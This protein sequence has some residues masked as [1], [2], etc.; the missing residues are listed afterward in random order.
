[1]ES[2]YNILWTDHAL[3][4]LALTF[5]YL[6]INFTEKELRKLSFV[7]QKT[8]KLISINPRLFP[9]S[10]SQGVRRV[11]ILKFNT[12]LYRNENDVIEILS[13]FSNRQDPLKMK[14]K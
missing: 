7:I 2:G 9:L 13:F 12:M 5:E 1:M 14:L 4:E 10:K 6:E 3:K 11:I 8:L